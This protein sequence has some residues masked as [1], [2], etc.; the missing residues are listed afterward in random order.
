MKPKIKEILEV[1]Q[2]TNL[3]EKDLKMISKRVNQIRHEEY[4]IHAA[5]YR[6]VDR[7]FKDDEVKQ[8]FGVVEDLKYRTFFMFLA[9]LGLRNSEA[10]RVKLE[11]INFK[12]KYVRI[13]TAKQNRHIYDLQ[14][15]P[16]V[17]M[18]YIKLY[19]KRYKTR[20]DCHGGWFFPQH[21]H[22]EKHIETHT[23][24]KKFNEYR[25]VCKFNMT[26][27]T[28]KD[29]R[30]PIHKKQGTRKLY[31]RTLHSFRHWYKVKLEKSKVP[32]GMI[33]SL[34]R[35]GRRSVTD[36]YGQYSLEE[37]KKAI[38]GVFD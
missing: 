13:K 30:N 29:E 11:D 2:D 32:Y 20:I 10:R 33:K 6:G 9:Y 16:S 19:L 17:L 24:R 1:I 26:Y 14:P 31:N 12:E 28:A 37:K 38:K 7:T 21:A 23:I 8:L 4:K 36:D 25:S 5:H 34:M 22:N 3:S 18:P 35:H 27:G 15:I